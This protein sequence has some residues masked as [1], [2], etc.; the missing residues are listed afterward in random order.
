MQSA[1]LKYCFSG[2]TGVL[3][4]IALLSALVRVAVPS[5]IAFTA[6]YVVAVA[7]QFLLNKYWSFSNFDRALHRQVPVYA[8]ITALNYVLMIAVEEAAI[9]VFGVSALVAYL[10]SVP[11]NVPV[12]YLANRYVTFGKRAE[13]AS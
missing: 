8:A 11:I 10:I 12:G 6:S 2:T 7:V 5:F 9:H 13:K 4:Y 3:V 1:F